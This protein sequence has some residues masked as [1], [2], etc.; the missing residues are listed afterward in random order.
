MPSSSSG[1]EARSSASD[2]GREARTAP[3]ERGGIGHLG[4]RRDAGDRFLREL[5]ELI[6]HGADQPAVDVDRAAAHPGDDA[7]LGQ[8]AAFELG[9]DEVALRRHHALER[10]DD[11]DGELLDGVAAEDGAPDADHAGTDLGHRHHGRSCADRPAEDQ[12]HQTGRDHGDG[13]HRAARHG[14]P[15]IRGSGGGI[16]ARPAAPLTDPQR[17]WY[18]SRSPRCGRC[19]PAR[20]RARASLAPARRVPVCGARWYWYWSFTEEAPGRP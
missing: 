4:D 7:G 6:G 14:L 8:R 18:R 10:A 20:F 1:V 9:Q 2:T 13:G 15:V 17:V 19:R 16:K 12:R 5:A 3:A 11:P